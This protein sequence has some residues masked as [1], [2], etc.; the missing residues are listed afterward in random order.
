M[1]LLFP[2]SEQREIEE[3]GPRAQHE[4]TLEN[5]LR[6]QQEVETLPALQQQDIESDVEDFFAEQLDIPQ[7]EQETLRFRTTVQFYDP[8]APPREVLRAELLEGVEEEKSE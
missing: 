6:P 7:V 4:G 1:S 8:N 2:S 5:P 3:L